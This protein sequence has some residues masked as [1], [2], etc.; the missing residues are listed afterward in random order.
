MLRMDGVN[1]IKKAYRNG[2]SINEIA[3]K[4]SRSW[5]TVK[6]IIDSSL[7][8]LKNRGSRPNEQGKVATSKVEEEIRSYLAKVEQFRVKKK[9][10]YT[11]VFIFKELKAKG[12]YNG[13]IRRL[14]DTVKRLRE[15]YGQLKPKSYLPLKVFTWQH[16]SV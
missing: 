14:Q 16:S 4:Y 7:E 6:R 13:S 8:E 2:G 10:R 9:Q 11:A 5:Y 3:I 12:V 15:E 1:K